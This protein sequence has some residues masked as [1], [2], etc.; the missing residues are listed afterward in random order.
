M[1][2][3]NTKKCKTF[4]IPTEKEFGKVNKNGNDDIITISYKIKLFH[5]ARFMASS[6]SG[7][8]DNL[9]EGIY[10][11]KCKDCDCSLKYESVKDNSIKYKC[12]SCKKEYSN[13]LDEELKKRLKNTFEFSNSDINKFIL[14]LTL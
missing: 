13:K 3:E 11:T 7:L 2:W 12:L 9:T 5:N 4:S 1:L 6:L 10:K 8:V 14:L